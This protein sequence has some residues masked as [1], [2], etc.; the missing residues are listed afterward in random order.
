M[1]GSPMRTILFSAEGLP[2]V[3]EHSVSTL[4]S[5]SSLAT[6]TVSGRIRLGLVTALIARDT[7]PSILGPA[8]LSHPLK[9]RK[10]RVMSVSSSRSR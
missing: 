1:H 6:A 3:R 7:L 4:V 2:T 8:S 9:R 10:V 5:R